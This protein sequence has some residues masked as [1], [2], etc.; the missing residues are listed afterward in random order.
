[1]N[2]LPGSDKKNIL[3]YNVGV[4]LHDN[5]IPFRPE[6]LPEG[7]SKKGTPPGE[8]IN[9]EDR[10]LI[11]DFEYRMGNLLDAIHEYEFPG[12]DE[13]EII[14]FPFDKARNKS[15]PPDGQPENIIKLEF[16]SLSSM[17]DDRDGGSDP[18]FYDEPDPGEST[19]M[20]LL[21]FITELEEVEH[22]DSFTDFQKREILEDLIC[23]LREDID[24]D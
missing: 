14:D 13:P 22:P 23:A 24:F 20:Q 21:H 4:G 3:N 2:L 10:R 9:L 5:I 6:L 1:M 16:A 17:E 18:F 12:T 7:K 19:I 15:V 8:I 11:M